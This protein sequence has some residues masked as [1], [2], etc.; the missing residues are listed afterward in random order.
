MAQISRKLLSATALAAV[1]TGFG[2]MEARA[3]VDTFN[4]YV[5]YADSLRPSGFFPSPWLLDPGVVSE[6]STGQ[7]FDSGAIRIQNTGTTVLNFTD[8]TVTMNGGGGPT[9]NF[10]NPL[11]VGVG[12]NG[13]FTQ[14]FQYNFDSSDNSP[15]GASPP[16]NIFPLDPGGNG[17]GGC[18]SSAAAQ[19]TAGITATC[20]A[21]QPIV[22]FMEN[23]TLFT[24]NDKGH[25]LDTGWYDFVFQSPDGNESIN[26]NLIGSEANRGGTVPEPST[27]AMMLFGFGGLGFVAYRTKKDTR[28]AVA[29]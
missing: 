10:W 24:L 8:F 3:A 2:A 20:N 14:T 4:V 7:L 11:S 25:I 6:S 16:G 15:N 17:I 29:A 18:S 21:E 5:G 12:Q 19:A 22:S 1:A 13:I 27:W 28:A 23:G 26:W 9:Y